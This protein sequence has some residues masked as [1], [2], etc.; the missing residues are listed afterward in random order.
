MGRSIPQ[1][2]LVLGQKSQSMLQTASQHSPLGL[3]KVHMAQLTSYTF[4]QKWDPWYFKMVSL[5]PVIMSVL[6]QSVSL[7]LLERRVLKLLARVLFIHGM[8]SVPAEVAECSAMAQDMMAELAEVARAEV[9]MPMLRTLRRIRHLAAVVLGLI[10][11]AEKV[12]LAS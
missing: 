12:P 11:L 6:A 2:G 7:A 10:K 5:M 9:L 1:S 3:K 4:I 8:N